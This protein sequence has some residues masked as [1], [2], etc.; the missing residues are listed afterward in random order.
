MHKQQTTSVLLLVSISLQCQWHVS[1]DLL[2]RR[3]TTATVHSSHTSEEIENK[4][5]ISVAQ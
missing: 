5:L 3:L 4:R 2:S 1:T